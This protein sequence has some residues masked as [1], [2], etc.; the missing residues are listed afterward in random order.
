MKSSIRIGRIVNGIPKRGDNVVNYDLWS[1]THVVKS[2]KWVFVE[3]SIMIGA[4]SQWLQ[5]TLSLRKFLT[6]G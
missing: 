4:K 5:D 1:R 3:S 2:A 6:Y